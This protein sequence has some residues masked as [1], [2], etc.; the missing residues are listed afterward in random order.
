M[1]L[2]SL[3]LRFIESDRRSL[4]KQPGNTAP[5]PS[6]SPSP[7]QSSPPHRP[8]SARLIVASVARRP[9]EEE[10]Y[11]LCLVPFL[12]MSYWHP[13]E[14]LPSSFAGTSGTMCLWH[15][16]EESH[17]SPQ[18]DRDQLVDLSPRRRWRGRWCSCSPS[19]TRTDQRSSVLPSRYVSLRGPVVPPRHTSWS[20]LLLSKLT[21]CFSSRCL[22]EKMCRVISC[23]R[24][25]IHVGSEAPVVKRG[26]VSLAV[27]DVL[28]TSAALCTAA[29]RFNTG[30]SIDPRSASSR[31]EKKDPSR[32]DVWHH[33]DLLP[34]DIQAHGPCLANWPACC[35]IMIDRYRWLT[36]CLKRKEKDCARRAACDFCCSHRDN[37][38][39]FLPTCRDAFCFGLLW[40]LRRKGISSFECT[41]SDSININNI[42]K[43]KLES[44]ISF[45]KMHLMSFYFIIQC[46][47]YCTLD[48]LSFFWR[49]RRGSAFC[50]ALAQ[51]QCLLSKSLLGFGRA[52]QLLLWPTYSSSPGSRRRNA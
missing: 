22:A 10:K 41:D 40:F 15:L 11:C 17:T 39:A 36:P 50:N 14:L 19:P 5:A 51:T 16:V 8:R 45:C 4:F 37:K 27:R 33:D 3:S 6:L 31:E 46:T 48:L 20:C 13:L 49:R 24:H 12:L 30:S 35:L 34:V 44:W 28:Q 42:K 21:W 18:G 47:M 2:I 25:I 9:I 26:P 43:G 7:P 38:W 52:L 1:N 29:S 32:C 23:D